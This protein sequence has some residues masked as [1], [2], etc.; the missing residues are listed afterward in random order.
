M[1][2]PETIKQEFLVDGIS[3]HKELEIT[4]PCKPAAGPDRITPRY[5]VIERNGK[6]LKARWTCPYCERHF[7]R[8]KSCHGHMG[9]IPDRKHNCPVLR[10]QEVERRI[11]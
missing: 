8:A 6:V 9:L 11:K 1:I 2:A 5:E 3:A 7:K 4:I 10:K